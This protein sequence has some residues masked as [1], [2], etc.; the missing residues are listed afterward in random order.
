MRVRWFGADWGAPVCDP[1]YHVSTPVGKTC[2]HCE[3]AI[4]AGQKGIV[5]GAGDGIP[6]TFELASDKHVYRVVVNHLRCHI[7][8]IMG[9]DGLKEVE[10]LVGLD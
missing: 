4:L 9:P 5:M 3:R 8:T 10:T 2:L 1:A 7:E 6:H